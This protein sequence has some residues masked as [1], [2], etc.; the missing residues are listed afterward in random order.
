ML[1]PGNLEIM[2][3]EAT[4]DRDRSASEVNR[5]RAQVASLEENV[6]RLSALAQQGEGRQVL[7]AS[8]FFP[9][10]PLCFSPVFSSPFPP[11]CRL[12]P[13]GLP[14]CRPSSFLT[15]QR[16]MEELQ[17]KLVTA[18]TQS[19]ELTKDNSGLRARLDSLG[20]DLAAKAQEIA[21]ASDRLSTANRQLQERDARIQ[22]LQ[23]A[24]A[25]EQAAQANAGTMRARIAALEHDVS[26]GKRELAVQA[27]AAS[28]ASDLHAAELAV[29]RQATK[30][31][32]EQNSDF[33][34]KQKRLERELA[35]AR[36]LLE[37]TKAVGCRNFPL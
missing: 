34:T 29:E 1:T 18:N 32:R 22:Q 23:A 36:D 25:R 9:F 31:L 27:Q 24:E 37:T 10:F 16:A 26:E 17:A 2:L 5:L 21:Q 7:P 8:C 3:E 12:S 30:T 35:S 11:C 15:G 19:Q 14:S 4:Q 33:E 28:N 20:A 13:A 6:T